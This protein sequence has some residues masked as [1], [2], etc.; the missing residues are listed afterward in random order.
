MVG[1]GKLC[2][3]SFGLFVSSC[4][5]LITFIV[6]VVET[7]DNEWGVVCLVVSAGAVLQIRSRRFRVSWGKVMVIFGVVMVVMI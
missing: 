3:T 6:N 2:R 7:M 5:P 1:R 4:L